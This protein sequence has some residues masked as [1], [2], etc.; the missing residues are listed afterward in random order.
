MKG[1]L[2]TISGTNVKKKKTLCRSCSVSAK[3][4]LSDSFVLLLLLEIK[5]SPNHLIHAFKG[6]AYSLLSRL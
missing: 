2:E 5:N 3:N 1:F 4:H 6:I